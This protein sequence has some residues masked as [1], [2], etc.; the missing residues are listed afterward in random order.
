[1]F[2]GAEAGINQTVVDF[3][4]IYNIVIYAHHQNMPI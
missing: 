1:M 4:T 3:V 2:N